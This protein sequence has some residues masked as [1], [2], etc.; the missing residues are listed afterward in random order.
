M[1]DE[2]ERI[3]DLAEALRDSENRIRGL[4][5]ILVDGLIVIDEQ[6]SIR[7]FNPAAEKIF[8]WTAGEVT[9]QSVNMLMPD[10]YAREHDG[11]V[12][13]YME[14][15]EA[16]II[17]IG[18]EVTGLR[19]DGTEFPMDLSVAEMN[20]RST[21]YFVGTVRDLS[22]R[23]EIEAELRQAHKMEA[24]GQLTGGVAHDFNNLL[25]VLMMDLELLA[26]MTG[27]NEEM[28]ELVTEARE[29]VHAGAELTQR[30]LAFSRRQSLQPRVLDLN[31]LISS[32][33][34]L[35]RRTLGEGVQIDIVGPSDL[36]P[37]LADPGQV[38][39]ALL[40]L[41]INARDA[42]EAGGRLTI[43]TANTMLD[44]DYAARQTDVEAGNY[45][46]LSV[47]D[48]GA[49][50]PPEIGEKVFDPFFST[51]EAGSGSGLG[52]SMVYGFVKQSG[53]HVA[54]YSEPG[55]GTTVNLYLP[56]APDDGTAEDISAPAEIV[57]GDE[58]VLLVEDHPQLRRRARRV[59]DELG[60]R[61][62]EAENGDSA[63]KIL[64]ARD[65]IELL[66]TDIV[67]PGALDGA[68]L[69]NEARK[70][71]P[72]I[73]ILFTTGYA[74]QAQIAEGLLEQGG[75]LLRKPY[76]KAQLSAKIRALLD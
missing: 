74:E 9:G 55:R 25:A 64:E 40:N 16:R 52:L 58:V 43:E 14:T 41:A 50:M 53:G 37:T 21:R 6:G 5:D 76:T 13:R 70:L 31:V 51:K 62:T 15:G 44:D 8:G 42:M 18:R 23:R 20:V 57:A 46:L 71:R 36:W 30:L 66:F 72:G 7:N 61:V 56:K 4:V 39:N 38:E 28:E 75:E 48:N 3:Q 29:V 10:S 17:G 12:T 47:T 19:K 32:V 63:L 65:D 11:Y 1:T 60:Y 22:E 26:E 59:L 54:I 2:A 69:A 27:D 49:G 35:L 68:A 24:L 45:V 73:R 34:S 67:M 33:A